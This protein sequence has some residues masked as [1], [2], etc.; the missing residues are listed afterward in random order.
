MPITPDIIERSLRLP[1]PEAIAYLKSKI[2]EATWDWDE[3]TAAAQQRAFT[4]AKLTQLDLLASVQEE[5]VAA[6][7]AG[8]T[9]ETFREEL[10][11]R[12]KA[13]GWWGLQTIPN[14]TTGALET[15]LT[16]APWRL[17]T[18]Y[19]TNTQSALMA[20]RYQQQ[21]AVAT[22]RPYWRYLAVGDTRTRPAHQTIN[23]KIVRA[24]DPFW[25]K[26][27]PPNGFNCRCRVE[28][29]SQAELEARGLSVEN[30][31]SL[32]FEPDK[33]FDSAPGEPFE[34]D[35]KRYPAPLF[36]AFRAAM[37]NREA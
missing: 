32:A 12:L 37:K 2:P 17:L 21:R 30:G 23:G 7:V 11:P 26:N 15:V 10:E 36:K 20:G 34:P 19:R 18:I 3:L 1:F 33:G 25:V 35:P 4:V 28:S 9:F 31:K 22:Q 5:L 16:G 13:R 14:P 6:Q 29:L 27:Y 24:D 8:T